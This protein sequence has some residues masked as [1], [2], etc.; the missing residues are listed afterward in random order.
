[1]RY[2]RYAGEEMLTG[3]EIA[4]AVERLAEAAAEHHGAARIRIPVQVVN[5]IAGEATLVVTPASQILTRPGPPDGLELVDHDAVAAIEERIHRVSRAG[6]SGRD[7][8]LPV[9]LGR[10]YDDL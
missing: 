6:A 2:V 5:G 3:D 10:W 1:M 9:H 7:T 8:T 4:D